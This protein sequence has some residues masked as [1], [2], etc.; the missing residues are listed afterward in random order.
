MMWRPEVD[1]IAHLP[2]VPCIS[3]AVSVC[4]VKPHLKKSVWI[5]LGNII[6]AWKQMIRRLVP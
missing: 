4:L 3:P 6:P 2:G 1:G 5:I